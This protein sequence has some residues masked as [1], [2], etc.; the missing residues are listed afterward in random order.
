MRKARWLLCLSCGVIAA[1]TAVIGTP[2]TV[3]AESFA[4]RQVTHF[5]A[6]VSFSSATPL[7]T[8]ND[9]LVFVANQ[10]TESG[11]YRTDGTSV[12]LIANSVTASTGATAQLGND[13]F[14]PATGPDGNELYATDG[15]TIREVADLN[16]GP[17]NSTP[18]N[19][20][21][22]NGQLFFNAVVGDPAGPAGSARS[23][24][25]RTDGSTVSQFP[26]FGSLS[27]KQGYFG[28]NAAQLGDKWIFAGQQ[29]LQG[30]WGIY[31][32]DGTSA[33]LITTQS[34]NSIYSPTNLSRVGNEVFFI[35]YIGTQQGIYSTDGQTAQSIATFQ[36]FIP[37]QFGTPSLF[38]L[39][40][41]AF[42]LN[43]NVSDRK[44][45]FF[46][47]DGHTPVTALAWQLP[48]GVN[49][50]SRALRPNVA[51]V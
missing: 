22:L 8:L 25:F 28:N 45:E 10:G 29:T 6:P 50:P 40:D 37:N 47:F 41:T 15:Q 32:T 23:N 9:Q 38:T 51:F 17:L 4:L 46:R 42:L 21:T 30:P 7:A 19:F 39:N 35:D 20:Q 16:P 1:I 27:T 33:K 13:L 18:T 44:L 48:T 5:A 31:S 24:F 3:T 34:A 36:S 11:L 26:V 12:S 14:F 2:T 43:E 49:F